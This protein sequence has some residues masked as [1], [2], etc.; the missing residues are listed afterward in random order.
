MPRSR[1]VNVRLD[2]AEFELLKAAA[3][4]EEVKLSVWIRDASLDAAAPVEPQQEAGQSVPSWLA[5]LLLYVH[6]IRGG[7][8]KPDSVDATR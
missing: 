8:G 3:D 4:A 5:A 2:D 1:Q 6:A 7:Q